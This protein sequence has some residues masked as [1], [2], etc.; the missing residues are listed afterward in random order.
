LRTPVRDRVL[1]ALLRVGAEFG[2]VGGHHDAADGPG[3]VA[4]FHILQREC[5]NGIL[6]A[7]R[8]EGF[9]GAGDG[10]GKALLA[11]GVVGAHAHQQHA[12]GADA[13]HAAQQQGGA[14]LAGDVTRLDGGSDLAVQVEGFGGL[15]Q[16]LVLEHCDCDAARFGCSQRVFCVECFY[17]KVHLVLRLS[18]RGCDMRVCDLRV[19]AQPAIITIE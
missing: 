18:I 5:D 13:G 10:A 16:F 17:A 11:D 7:E 2:F 19:A 6:G 15:R 9:Q 12:G 4:L 14:G 3:Q 8:G 1:L